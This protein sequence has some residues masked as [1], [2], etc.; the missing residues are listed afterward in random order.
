MPK[1][2]IAV[3]Y[4]RRGAVV[5]VR[6]GRKVAR[7]KKGKKGSSEPGQPSAGCH[8]VAIVTERRFELLVCQKPDKPDDPKPPPGTDPCCYRDPETGDEW[9]WC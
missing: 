6:K 9:C 5:A 4:D 8:K 2:F 1:P 7:R 3:F